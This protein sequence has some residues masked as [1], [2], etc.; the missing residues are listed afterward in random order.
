[1]SKHKALWIS[2]AT[3]V[4]LGVWLLT[5]AKPG[6]PYYQGHSLSHWLN[7]AASGSEE[8]QTAVRAIGTNAIPVLVYWISYDPLHSRKSWPWL[9]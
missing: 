6:E 1:M 9:Q 7:E 8:A 5:L 3:A 4:V 2:L